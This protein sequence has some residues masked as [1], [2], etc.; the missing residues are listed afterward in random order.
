MG[1]RSA[2]CRKT[3]RR[4]RIRMPRKYPFPLAS[5][6]IAFRPFGR[7]LYIRFRTAPV[8]SACFSPMPRPAPISRRALGLSCTG[9]Y[10]RPFIIAPGKTGHP[11]RLR[12]IWVYFGGINFELRWKNNG[13]RREER[14][15][16]RSAAVFTDRA[17]LSCCTEAIFIAVSRRDA[18]PAAADSN[19]VG[20]TT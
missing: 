3:A 20:K 13:I 15:W 7:R 4:G 5:F 19:Y 11:P 8:C 6:I 12:G 18:I 2:A 10:F 16:A 1:A 17:V 14:E 9:R